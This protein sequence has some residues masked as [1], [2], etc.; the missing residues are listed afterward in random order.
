MPSAAI[1]WIVAPVVLV[2]IFVLAYKIARRARQSSHAE[3]IAG[4]DSSLGPYPLVGSE[5]TG[6]RT[7]D[8]GFHN[9][10]DAS[11]DSGA[12]DSSGGD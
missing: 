3:S 6:P 2:A 7:H 1:F 9:H 4:S 11:S 8:A 10:G 5:N 12:G